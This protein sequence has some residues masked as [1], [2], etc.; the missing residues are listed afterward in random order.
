MAALS[1]TTMVRD[2][3]LDPDK[4]TDNPIYGSM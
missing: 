2:R 1:I 3:R 4:P